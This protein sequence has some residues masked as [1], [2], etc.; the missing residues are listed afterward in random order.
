MQG[1]KNYN[2]AKNM[3]NVFFSQPLD[4]FTSLL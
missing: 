1:E 2:T 4:R 3:P